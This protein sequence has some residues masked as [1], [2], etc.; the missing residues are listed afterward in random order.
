MKKVL[1]VGLVC[2]LTIVSAFAQVTT[3]NIRG[4]VTDDLDAPLLGANVIAV[5]TPTGT[6]YGAITN[7]EG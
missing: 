7:E 6:T 5:H 1:L 2:M 4:T 3:S